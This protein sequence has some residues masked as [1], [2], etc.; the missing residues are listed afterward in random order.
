MKLKSIISIVVVVCLII[1]IAIY[2][3]AKPSSS[4]ANSATHNTQVLT[5]NNGTNQ[6]STP[7]STN[8]QDVHNLVSK[9]TSSDTNTTSS[10]NKSTSNSSNVNTNT[11]NNNE[12]SS[13]TSQSNNN[14]NTSQNTGFSMAQ[15]TGNFADIVN[16]S[17]YIIGAIDGTHIIIPV[18]NG[19]IVNNQL[20][21]PEYYTSEPGEVFTAKISSLGNGNFILYEFYGNKHTATFK[22]KYQACADGPASLL[23]TFTHNGTSSVTGITFNFSQFGGFLSNGMPFYHGS[24]AGTPVTLEINSVG[25]NKYLEYYQ[26]D[27]NAFTLKFNYNVPRN[28]NIGFNEYYNGQLTGEYLLNSNSSN[29]TLTGEFIS[30]PGQ[31]NSETYPVTLQGSTSFNN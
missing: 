29:T 28:Y 21:L 2:F 1:L 11:S 6:V 17:N 13:S 15:S 18:S 9:T 7:K 20:I 25:Q 3:M 19:Q 31:S 24:V 4:T 22:L 14:S 30:H 26:G 10:N 23:G 27:Q 5:S 16:G 8:T 12:V